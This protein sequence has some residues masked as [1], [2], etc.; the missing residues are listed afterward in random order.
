V[1][2]FASSLAI[3]RCCIA[4]RVPEDAS[5]VQSLPFDNLLFVL[6]SC[7]ELAIFFCPKCRIRLCYKCNMTLTLKDLKKIDACLQCGEKLR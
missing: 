6:D 1:A 2:S 5:R 3:M 7:G 4:N